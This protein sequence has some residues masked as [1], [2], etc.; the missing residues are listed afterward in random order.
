MRPRR[1]ALLLP[2][3]LLVVTPTAAAAHAT[4]VTSYANCTAVHAHYKGGIAKVGAKDKRKSGG[5]ARY[6]PYV[7]TALYTA[8]K[9]MDRD[10]D[11]IACEQ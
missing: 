7:S 4:G 2:A 8:N 10:R 3:V 5:H 11:G 6:K 9:K 1:L